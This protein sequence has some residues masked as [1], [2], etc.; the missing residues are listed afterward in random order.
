MECRPQGTRCAGQGFPYLP[1]VVP[2]FAP[3]FLPVLGTHEKAGVMTHAFSYLLY[4]VDTQG[5]YRALCSLCE[6]SAVFHQ[7]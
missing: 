5:A 2:P 7:R 1:P 3:F 4:G 6:K